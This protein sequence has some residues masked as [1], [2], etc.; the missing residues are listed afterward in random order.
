MLLKTFHWD[1]GMEAQG[2]GQYLSQLNSEINI[3]K[4]MLKDYC[5]DNYW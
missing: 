2:P 3:E 5:V 1:E 4:E